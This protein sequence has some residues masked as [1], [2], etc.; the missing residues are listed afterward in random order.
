MYVERWPLTCC[1]GIIGYLRKTCLSLI[2]QLCVLDRES[3]IDLALLASPCKHTL[4]I[5]SVLIPLS[6]IEGLYY[7]A[8]FVS[9]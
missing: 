6:N 4:S 9:H 3:A 7:I 1:D 5:M 2:T 8:F